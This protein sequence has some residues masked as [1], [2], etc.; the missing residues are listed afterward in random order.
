MIAQAPEDQ[1]E[2][3]RGVIADRVG[4]RF[5]NNK[6]GMLAEI[7][8]RRSKALNC[9]ADVYLWQLEHD[10]PRNEWGALASE[11]TVGETYFFRNSEQFAALAEVVLPERMRIRAGKPLRLLS[12]GCSS[13]EEAYSLA[14]IARETLDNVSSAVEILAGDLNPAV[15]RR[16]ERAHY[17]SWALRE[18][19]PEMRAR[20]FRRDGNEMVLDDSIRCAVKFETVNLADDDA[21]IWQPGAYDVVFCRNVLMY[22]EPEQMRAAI[23]RIAHSLAAG[24]F[25]FLGHAETLRGISDRF[26]I[27]NTHETFYYRLKEADEPAQERVVR[28]VP[29]RPIQHPPS[30]IAD[31]SWFDQIKRASERVAQLVPLAE[32]TEATPEQAPALFDPSSVLELMRKERYADALSVVREGVPSSALNPQSILIEA[33]LLTHG[34]QLAAAEALAM[35]LLAID[36]QNA[37]AHYVLALCSEHAGLAER[38]V[39]HHRTAARIDPSFAMPRLHLGLLTRRAGERQLARDEFAKA[40]FLLAREDAQRLIL[41]GGGFNRDALMA[42]CSSALAECEARS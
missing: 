13:G 37:A 4:L 24:G 10:P 7:L 39:E 21:Y 5:E 16:A 11:L 17:S 18:T 38:A 28:L 29:R 15:L 26:N 12:A 2:R 27:V 30:P 23:A 34:G 3:F 31:T 33:I 25:L 42:L 8:H 20:W 6:L 35:R 1:A 14:I 41:F 40:L 22:F 9:N 36:S 19:P 32:T